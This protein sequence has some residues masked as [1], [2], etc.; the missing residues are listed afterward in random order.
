MACTVLLHCPI[1][2][3]IRT[4]DSQSNL[5]ILFIVFTSTLLLEELNSIYESLSILLVSLQDRES[6]I[7]AIESTFDAAQRPVSNV[8]LHVLDL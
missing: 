6:Q 8:R 5:R 2:A 3:E 1:S 7:A 4:V